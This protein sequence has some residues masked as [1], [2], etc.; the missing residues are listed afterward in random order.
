MAKNR[1]HQ[2]RLWGPDKGQSLIETALSISVLVF[3]LT[4]ALDLGRAAM[5]Y[6]QL[7][8]GAQ[9]GARAGVVSTNQEVIQNAAISKLKG[10]NSGTVSVNID[11]NG[12]YTEV[13]LTYNYQPLI[14]LLAAIVGGNTIS[15]SN[16]ARMHTLNGAI[17]YSGEESEL[18]DGGGEGPS[19]PADDGNPEN[20]DDDDEHNYEPP[21]G[22]DGTVPEENNNP[23]DEFDEPCVNEAPGSSQG[24][25]EQD[26]SHDSEVDSSSHDSEHEQDNS[27][28]SE[29]DGSSH[30]SEVEQDNSHD[31]E[32][33]N[34]SHDSEVDSS[35]HDSGDSQINHDCGNSHGQQNGDNG[36]SGSESDSSSSHDS[37]N[38]SDHE[39][40]SH[41]SSDSE[42]DGDHSSHE[43]NSSDQNDD[44]N[45]QQDVSE[46]HDSEQSHS[47]S[48]DDHQDD[49]S[50]NKE[51]GDEH[52]ND[53]GNGNGNGNGHNGDT[54]DD[55]QEYLRWSSMHKAES[56]GE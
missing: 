37:E 1:V 43:N 11:Q 19:E 33:D 48:S 7:A 24:E 55:Y 13:T 9:A 27:H 30:D 12:D 2:T 25:H 53:N 35:G 54:H 22:D 36:E 8:S 14:P 46:G 16:T 47:D 28:D 50:K 40:E 41:H 21:G 39:S 3:F 4:A 44:H 15:L 26:N 45:D 5:I 31:S 20:D 32:V 18:F 6:T 34:S 56:E 17:G 29:V 51:K 23:E 49:D 42:A 38:S 52:D 10:F